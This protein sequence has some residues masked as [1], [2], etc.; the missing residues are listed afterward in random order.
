MA[1]IDSLNIGS[2]DLKNENWAEFDIMEQQENAKE[3]TK[4]PTTKQQEEV[5]RMRAE[6]SRSR[7]RHARNKKQEITLNNQNNFNGL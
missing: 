2:D 4:I 1:Q 7:S 6:K 3:P 5:I